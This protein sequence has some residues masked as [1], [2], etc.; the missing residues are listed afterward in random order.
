MDCTLSP[1]QKKKKADLIFLVLYKP[2]D[3]VLAVS[4]RARQ[5]PAP[6]SPPTAYSRAG[7]SDRRSP[8]GRIEVTPLPP[9]GPQRKPRS[10]NGCA[11]PGGQEAGTGRPAKGRRRGRGRAGG[12]TG[13][14]GSPRS[15][16]S[17]RLM[18]TLGAPKLHRQAFL[19]KEE[20]AE[21]RQAAECAKWP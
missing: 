6:P 13:V 8:A 9:L 17:S 18:G 2:T 16:E 5:S 20:V 4:L 12:Q 21:P 1:G 14:T 3:E 11:L 19:Q 15:P 10:R 7:F